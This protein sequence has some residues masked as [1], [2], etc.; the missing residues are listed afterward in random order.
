MSVDVTG[1]VLFTI[2]KWTNI[3]KFYIDRLW[4]ILCAIQVHLLSAISKWQIVG[5]CLEN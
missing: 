4:D 3:Q 1:D 2:F 5:G